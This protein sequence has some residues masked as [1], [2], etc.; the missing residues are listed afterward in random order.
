MIISPEVR[1]YGPHME[2]VGVLRT[3]DALRLARSLGADLVE[4]APHAQPPVCGI[5]D[6]GKFLSKVRKKKGGV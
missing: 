6:Y 5:L 2:Q 1:V 4:I 3:A